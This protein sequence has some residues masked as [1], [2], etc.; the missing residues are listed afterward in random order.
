MK[1]DFDLENY[2]THELWVFYDKTF[3]QNG[4]EGFLISSDT[5]YI[6]LTVSY[7]AYVGSYIFA[8]DDVTGD[9]VY[10]SNMEIVNAQ[11]VISTSNM[12]KDD[13]DFSFEIIN[14][15]YE[16]FQEEIIPR[17]SSL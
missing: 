8:I 15:L 14:A 11:L 5:H 4:K 16:F 3:W 13:W 2:V 1:D 9:H 17:K 7:N 6:Y 10:I 12:L